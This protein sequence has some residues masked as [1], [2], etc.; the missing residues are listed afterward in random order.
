MAWRPYSA[1]ELAVGCQSG[2]C[3][4]STDHS[5]HIARTLSQAI[6]LTQ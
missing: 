6:H 1:N 5:L 4:W 2:V 3:L